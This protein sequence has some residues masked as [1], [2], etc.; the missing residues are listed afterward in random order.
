MTTG[1][2]LATAHPRIG[3]AEMAIFTRLA[4]S[5]GALAI[6]TEKTDFLVARLSSRLAAL[7]LPDFAAYAA[8]LTGPVG[9]AEIGAFIEALTTHTT[10]FFRENAQYDWLRD[11]GFPALQTRGA[12][13]HRDLV[14]WSAAASSGQELYSA[15]MT[16]AATGDREGV[17]L[18][19]RA[20]GTDLSGRILK[21]SQR[22][23]Y[24]REEIVDIPE[25]IRR[26]FLLSATDG[27]DR[28]R[29]S[30]DL[31]RRA[32]WI[33]AN[34]AEDASLP[35]VTVDLV[36]LRNVLIYFDAETRD[37]VLRNVVRRIG[38]GGY[39]LTG[40]SETIDPR[41]YGLSAVRPSIY[42]KDVA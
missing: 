38:P 20:I 14:I 13:L 36:M 11:S 40:H 7:G 8:H 1:P 3:P 18:R 16:A 33:R 35:A 15:M 4:R 2:A 9:D 5:R 10:R 6:G 17:D 24:T 31:R 42:S 34:L 12:G 22:G 23:I 27:S 19:L 39:L 37:R 41:G 28:V 32:R 30:P 29:I 26:R 21:Q 25:A